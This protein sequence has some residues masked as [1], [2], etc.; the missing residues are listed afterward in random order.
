MADSENSRTLPKTTRRK[1]QNPIGDRP[2]LPSRIDRKNLLGAVAKILVTLVSELE[3]APDRKV[4]GPTSTAR[5]WLNWYEVHQRL[6]HITRYQQKTESKVLA[7]AGA[8]PVLQI[9]ISPNERPV[10]VYTIAEI[11]RLKSRVDPA[12]L[13]SARSLLRKRRER[14][15]EADR[16][17]GYSPALAFEHDLAEQ[18]GRLSRILFLS[19]PRTIVEATAKLHCLMSTQDPGNK[20]KDAPWPELRKIL[21]DLIE[22]ELSGNGENFPNEKA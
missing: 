16:K 18:E 8:F 2:Q 12:Q 4:P 6:V 9:E 1:R 5:L 13:A 20:G 3:K 10:T 7:M 14:W 11:N 17:L 22:V 21:L 15:N 19:K